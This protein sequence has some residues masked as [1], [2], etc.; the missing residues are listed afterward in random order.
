MATQLLIGRSKE[1]AILESRYRSLSAEFVAVYGRRRV[2]K[3]YLVREV[4]QDR[5]TFQHTGVANA[6]LRDQLDRFYA[7]LLRHFDAAERW[8]PP[9]NWFEAFDLLI[10]ALENHANPGKKVVFLDELPWLDT[11]NSRFLSALEH[12]WNSWASARRDILLIVCGSAAAWMVKNLLHNKGGLHNRVTERIRLR[13]FTLAETDAFLKAK[14]GV[15]DPYQTVLLYMAFGGI[16]FYLEKIRTD[17]SI[18]QN[19]NALCFHSDAPL[20]NEYDNLYRSLFDQ[21]DQHL[22]IVEALS[23]KKKGLDRAEIVRYTGISDGGSLT[24]LLQE[25]E[26]S[27]FIR[28]YKAF[29]KKQRDPLYQLVDLFSLFHHTFIKHTDPDDENF[30]LNAHQTPAYAA[31]SGYAY[32]MVCLLHLPQIKEA[33]GIRGV[34]TSVSSWHNAEAQVDLVIDRKDQ[35]IHLCE[36][37]FSL[38]PFAISKAYSENLHRKVNA[39]REATGTRKAIFLT[40]ISTY[41]LAPGPYAGLVQNDIRMEAL[42]KEV[43]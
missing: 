15:Y 39:F 32:E 28:K 11:R 31:W 21:A 40:L 10:S 18:L 3:T 43:E 38:A 25:L 7:S 6:G 30:W 17:Q 19:V 1:A 29:G 37:K 33:L 16:P 35:V 27:H 26:E 12:F 41:G 34:Q 14:G 22:K 9:Q 23:T 36:I 2:G 42:F 8:R 4:F 24:R 20:R 13:P 5:L